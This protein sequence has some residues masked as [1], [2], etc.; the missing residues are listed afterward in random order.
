MDDYST[1]KIRE[2]LAI[3]RSIGQDMDDC[4]ILKIREV[5]AIRQSME[6]G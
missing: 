5:L 2:F 6:E 3:R 4:S 1:F